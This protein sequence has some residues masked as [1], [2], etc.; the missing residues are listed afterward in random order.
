MSGPASIVGPPPGI[1]VGAFC[2]L[3][4]E[5]MNMEVKTIDQEWRNF[6]E[7]VIDPTAPDVQRSEMR[8]AFYGG[9]SVMLAK[10]VEL[11]ESDSISEAEGMR[12]VDALEKECSDF[13]A[14]R[15]TGK[16]A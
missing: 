15:A 14:E 16:R 12:A 8:M 2:F 5:G 9:A 6:A 3:L 7:M 13:A 1:A 11:T 10:L 4:P